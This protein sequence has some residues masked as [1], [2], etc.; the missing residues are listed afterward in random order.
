MAATEKVVMELFLK[1]KEFQKK[2][3]QSMK[4]TT[5]FG[6]QTKRMSKDASTAI[7]GIVAAWVAVAATI[8]AVVR[9]MKAA[10]ST[11][12]DFTE[13]NSKFKVV[14][15]GVSSEANKMRD[16]LVNS[17]LMSRLEAT[18]F[19][20]TIQDMLVPM[21]IA[22]DKAAEMS[23]QIAK[24]S[25]D[26]ASFN[27]GSGATAETVLQAMQSAL[28][29]QIEPMRRY[30]VFLT[31]NRIKQEAVN[32]GYAKAGEELTQLA[33][34]QAI[35]SIIVADSAD[36]M[37]DVARTSETWANTLK[38]LRAIAEDL[39]VAIGTELIDALRPALVAIAKFAGQEGGIQKLARALRVL[40]NG[41]KIIRK[42]IDLAVASLEAF[43]VTFIAFGMTAKKILTA[44]IKSLKAIV[45]FDFD[46]VKGAWVGAF[47]D[48][49]K[50]ILKGSKVWMSGIEENFYDL[51]NLVME[52]FA[53][54]NEIIEEEDA[55]SLARQEQNWREHLSAKAVLD[56]KYFKQL[57]KLQ[58]QTFSVLQQVSDAEVARDEVNI[59]RR[60]DR[61]IAALEEERDR[62]ILSD[63]QFNDA[64]AEA[65]Q[66]AEHDIAVQKRK[67]ARFEKKLNIAQV[68]IN[69]AVSV[70]KA[71]AQLG[72]I[73]GAISAAVLLVLA[74][75]QTQAI[76]TQPLP[77]VPA[78]ASGG[79]V[80]RPTMAMVGEAGPEAVVPL[81]SDM[82]TG[83]LAS[84]AGGGDS[85]TMNVGE[86]AIVINVNG[87]TPGAVEEEVYSAVRRISDRM[88][89]RSLF[90]AG[91]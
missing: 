54:K 26:I 65:N 32:K 73:G 33:K 5:T 37:G 58:K 88:G 57:M 30:G 89:Q 31:Q 63:Q 52:L 9:G 36:A 71:F 40:L 39:S 69:Y 4:G 76:Q 68:W 75:L 84:A 59:N 70:M 64:R 29:G 3:A 79:I 25:A 15:R 10:I 74:G 38:R 51:A 19:L 49:G 35:L 8:V 18:K 60:R 53:E 50:E 6:K 43:R 13:A 46:A 67:S 81:T 22:R 28:A 21:G 82:A 16:E 72:P 62:G 44:T 91:A 2:L 61:R 23:G 34:S 47:E 1:N 24:L 42:F 20:S 83:L 56:N 48:I 17:Y 90:R 87:G 66:Q 80:T 7:G 12:S 55:N 78:L 86:G 77:A 27:Q 85:N 11:A 14:F 41:F 45:T